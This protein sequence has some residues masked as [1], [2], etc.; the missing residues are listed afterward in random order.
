MTVSAPDAVSAVTEGT[1]V[2]EDTTELRGLPVLLE[3][4]G[5]PARPGRLGRPVPLEDRR[6]LRVPRALRGSKE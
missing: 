3:W 2:I 4:L 5:R 1:K 6:A